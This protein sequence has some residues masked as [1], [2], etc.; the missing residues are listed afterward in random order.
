M[1]AKA[2]HVLNC[3]QRVEHLIKHIHK[4]STVQFIDSYIFK[5]GSFADKYLVYLLNVC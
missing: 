4:N 1:L 3:H 5:T 2:L